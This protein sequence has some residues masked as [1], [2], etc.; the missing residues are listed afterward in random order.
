MDFPQD[1]I[2]AEKILLSLCR[3]KL[4]GGNRVGFCHGTGPAVEWTVCELRG[5]GGAESEPSVVRPA[6][7]W[8]ASA[9]LRSRPA[10][11]HRV[12]A[13]RW[14]PCSVTRSSVAL[15]ARA[16]AGVHADSHPGQ[17]RRR[18]SGDTEGKGRASLQSQGSPWGQHQA[19]IP[20]GE[21]WALPHRPQGP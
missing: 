5:V 3:V 15:Q 13:A 18:G 17:A 2:W 16:A 14:P 21:V 12:P 20:P 6:Q 10:V 9:W 11:A 8:E 7:P 19:R 1:D 4:N